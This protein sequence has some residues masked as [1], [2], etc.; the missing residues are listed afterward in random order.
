MVEYTDDNVPITCAECDV[1]LEGVPEM[2]QHILASHPNYSPQEAAE[3]AHVWADSSYEEID[4]QDT[5]R[6]EEYRRTGVDPDD[7]DKD[8][9]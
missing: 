8:P 9:F 1:R 6:T 3:Y 2:V 7:I 5:W 4:A